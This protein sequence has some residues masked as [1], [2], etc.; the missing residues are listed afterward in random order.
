[1]KIL[2]DAECVVFP[3]PRLRQAKRTLTIECF[4]IEVEA[5]GD[6]KRLACPEHSGRRRVPPDRRKR[7]C[8]AA[9]GVGNSPGIVILPTKFQTLPIVVKRSRGIALRAG[10]VSKTVSNGMAVNIGVARDAITVLLQINRRLVISFGSC[11]ISLHEGASSQH[12]PQ[13]D[14]QVPDPFRLCH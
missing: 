10:Y 7:A 12:A 11:D 13:C 5:K 2:I 3:F 8:N 9:N 1:M 4:G 14:H 6:V